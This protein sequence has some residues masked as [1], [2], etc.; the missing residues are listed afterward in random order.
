[1]NDI[2]SIRSTG[3]DPPTEGTLLNFCD[4]DTVED[5]PHVEKIDDLNY[6]L[7]FDDHAS[8]SIGLIYYTFSND[9]GITWAQPQSL[10]T[11]NETGTEIQPHLWQ[12]QTDGLWWIYYVSDTIIQGNQTGVI[13]RKPLLGTMTPGNFDA[14]GPRELVI[15]P[16]STHAESLCV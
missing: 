12:N 2:Y 16:T 4:E 9:S 7:V 8:D 3:Y 11:V 6:I 15:M 1:M 10:T 5:N 14:F 13:F